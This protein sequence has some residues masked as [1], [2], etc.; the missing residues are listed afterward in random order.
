MSLSL[1]R[2]HQCFV[3]KRLLDIGHGTLK[4]KSLQSSTHY[5]IYFPPFY[6]W[7]NWETERLCILHKLLQWRPDINKLTLQP[8]LFL[9]YNIKPKPRVLNIMFTPAV[10]GDWIPETICKFLQVAPMY[11]FSW[12]EIRAIFKGVTDLKKSLKALH[13]KRLEWED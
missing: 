4:I 1:I 9:L 11:I 2:A 10:Q 3:F 5:W 6:R 8:M 12:G 7:R 13:L